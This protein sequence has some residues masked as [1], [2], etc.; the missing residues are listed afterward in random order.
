MTRT[1]STGTRAFTYGLDGNL[2]NLTLENSTLVDYS[3]DIA[4]NRLAR[5]VNGTVDAQWKWD[6]VGDQPVRVSET[7]ATYHRWFADPQSSLG[8]A[9]VEFSSTAVPTWLVSDFQGN[10]TGTIK[11]AGL[12]GTAKYGAFGED[13][14]VTGS[15]TT[16]PLRFHGQYLDTVSGLVD[17]RARDYDPVIG[18]FT[19]TD[20]VATKPGVPF[21]QTYNYA[22]NQP[23]LINDP[24][25]ACAF[26]ISG[27]IGA[28]IGGVIGG[29][30][31]GVTGGNVWAGIGT[32]MLVGGLTGAL[33]GAGAGRCE[34]GSSQRR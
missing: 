5:A 15:M 4:G 30:A 17:M 27:L 16:Q 13:L 28:V 11:T 7:G 24:S 29:V 10:V 1:S 12:T 9:A 32:G 14:A 31:A 34:M 8:T 21:A 22:F 18:R 25:G 26:C 19:G 20:P 6:T 23:T 2:Y 3:Y 33:G